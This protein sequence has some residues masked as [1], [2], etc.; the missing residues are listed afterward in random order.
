MLCDYNNLNCTSS[1]QF[2]MEEFSF[3]QRFIDHMCSM[4]NVYCG[5]NKWL[6]DL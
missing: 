5:C 6:K 2:H 4:M 3:S 1:T